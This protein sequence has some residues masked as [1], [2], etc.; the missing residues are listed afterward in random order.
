M[1]TALSD[2]LRSL[3]A[4]VPVEPPRGEATSEELQALAQRLVADPPGLM[5]C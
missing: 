3:V 1:S 4:E 5:K 2:G